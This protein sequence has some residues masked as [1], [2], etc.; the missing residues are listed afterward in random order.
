MPTTADTPATSPAPHF[1]GPADDAV[2]AL[3]TAW[4]AGFA[5]HDPAAIAAL[6]AQDALFYG[7]LPALYR[8]P[9]GV[10]EYFRALAVRSGQAAFHDLVVS[11]AGPDIRIVAGNATFAWN[12]GAPVTLRITQVHVRQHGA[13]K[14]LNH[15]VSTR[16]PWAPPSG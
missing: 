6:Y 5:A 3:L 1:A 16:P 15:H 11:S 10:L 7:S 2:A 12:G 13:W 8:G 9:A 4:A 14:I